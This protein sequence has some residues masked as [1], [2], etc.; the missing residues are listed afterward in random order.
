MGRWSKLDAGFIRHPKSR[1]A[2]RHGREVFVYA[3]CLN[4]EHD[5]DGKI[6][7]GFFGPNYLSRELEMSPE[8]AAAAFDACNASLLLT[9]DDSHVSIVGWDPVEWGGGKPS[10]HPDRV[11]QRVQQHRE[12]K[13]EGANDVTPPPVTGNG[14][15]AVT[16]EER[17][18][19]ESVGRKKKR[20]LPPT[21]NPNKSHTEQATTLGLDLER[22]A[23]NFRNHAAANGR[24][25]VDWDASFRVW[26]DKATDFRP[27]KAAKRQQN[28][29]AILAAA[30]AEVER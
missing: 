7:R 19:E 27:A 26:L 29:A 13:R 10:T 30:N 16:L 25:Q 3:L 15:N 5:F 8:E 4:A 28:I 23:K 2:G 11:R 9:S 22:E 21:W 24:T 14:S 18:G 20:A 17:R 6:P 1:A 12:R